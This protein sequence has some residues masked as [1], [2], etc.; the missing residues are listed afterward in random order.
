MATKDTAEKKSITGLDQ[1]SDRK[2]A[3]YDLVTSLL[4]AAAFKEAD[5]NIVEAKITRGGKY[6]FSVHL[7]PLS[8]TDA[9]FARKQAT[10]YMPNPNNR[11]LPP[12]E[13]DV[14]KVKMSSWIIY[15]ATTEADQKQIWGNP[16]IMQK[17]GLAQPW[18]TVDVLLKYGE[19]EM[20]SQIISDI[21]EAEDEV[22]V[23]DFRTGTDQ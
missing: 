11:K 18:E 17:Y 5:D 10:I 16:A 23:E 9:V 21:S 3:E 14:D 12:I 13:K 2:E 22:S 7:H 4:E 15:L 6:L 1:A 8:E 19:K 20:L